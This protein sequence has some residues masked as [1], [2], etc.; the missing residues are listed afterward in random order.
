MA[1]NN[2]SSSSREVSASPELL[3]KFLDLQAQE[4]ALRTEG[5]QIQKADIANQHSIAQQS[6]A[7]QLQD[8]SHSRAHNKSMAIILAITGSFALTALLAFIWSMAHEGKD[9]LLSQI[10]DGLIDLVKFLVGGV[11]GYCIAL[12]KMH[13]SPVKESGDE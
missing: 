2:R 3:N 12:A 5:M 4:L 6:I 7:A 10:M 13:R 11:T 1:Q 9:A 8:R